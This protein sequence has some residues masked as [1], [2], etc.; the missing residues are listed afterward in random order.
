[1][2]GR[3]LAVIAVGTVLTVVVSACSSSKSSDKT[4]SSGKPASLPSLT[5][6]VPLATVGQAWPYIAQAKGYYAKEGVNV[7]LLANVG[8]NN[9]VP[10]VLAGKADLTFV[11]AGAAFQQVAQGNPMVVVDGLSGNGL[12]GYLMVKAG[13]GITDIMQLSGKKVAT[14]GASGNGWGSLQQLSH[15]VVDHG[16][17]AFQAVPV[18]DASTASAELLSGQVSALVGSPDTWVQQISD[19]QM[20]IMLRMDNAANQTKYLGGTNFAVNVEF[21]RPSVLKSKRSAVT[22]YVK[23]LDD[24]NEF[25]KT[26]TPEEIAQT[27]LTLPAFKA[28]KLENAVDSAKEIKP[29]V[30]SSTEITEDGWQKLL[31][32]SQYQNIQGFKPDDDKFSFKS[33]VDGSYFSG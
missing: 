31:G 30:L 9:N 21:G 32:I 17:K 13:S 8:L 3:A 24:A 33:M 11:G 7:K 23:A 10:M 25:M 29:F 1:M 14:K 18:D 4:G 16:G 22:K 28:V 15:Y 5:V 27:L 12:G 26:S 20:T 6:A 2:H 19:G